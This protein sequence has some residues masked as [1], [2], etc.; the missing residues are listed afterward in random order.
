MSER[1]LTNAYW[2]E[3][4]ALRERE[5]ILDLV[6]SQ[7]CDCTPDCGRLDTTVEKVINLIKEDPLKKLQQ[8]AEET[9]E[10]ENF[11]NPLIDKQKQNTQ[12]LNDLLG[13]IGK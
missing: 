10:H 2:M 4:G 13:I 6:S 3:V 1:K 5:R 12:E 9:G 8:L 11:D 7:V